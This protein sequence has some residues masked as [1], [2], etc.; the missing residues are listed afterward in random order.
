MG[1]A[2]CAATQLA[3]QLAGW[4]HSLVLHLWQIW[5]T[6]VSGWTEGTANMMRS[7]QMLASR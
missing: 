1:A 2:C 3:Q 6:V 4:R 5:S 7:A